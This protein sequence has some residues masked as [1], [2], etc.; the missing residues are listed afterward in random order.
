MCTRT[1]KKLL[2]RD[3]AVSQKR[4][5]E[6][7]C[8]RIQTEIFHKMLDSCTYP[9]LYCLLCIFSYFSFMNLVCG[10]FL[11]GGCYCCSAGCAYL[12]ISKRGHGQQYIPSKCW[13]WELS[14]CACLAITADAKCKIVTLCTPKIQHSSRAQFF[15]VHNSMITMKTILLPCRQTHITNGI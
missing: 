3:G 10:S 4:D 2:Y 11:R 1:T 12:H 14:L 9:L 8:I 15:V 5:R 13:V 6:S 7:I